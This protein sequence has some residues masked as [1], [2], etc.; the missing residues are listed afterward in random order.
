MSAGVD[1]AANGGSEPAAAPPACV[2]SPAFAIPSASLPAPLKGVLGE[3]RWQLV[4]GAG[5]D[6]SAGLS[7]VLRWAGGPAPAGTDDLSV[8][9]EFSLAVRCHRRPAADGSD[10]GAGGEGGRETMSNGC[11][12]LAHAFNADSPEAGERR[13]ACSRA[14]LLPGPACP[15]AHHRAP[16][17]ATPPS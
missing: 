2:A 15:A 10:G 16:L 14:L 13:Q 9:C 5:D 1:S 12:W 17:H 3:Q 8:C 11:S 4:C 6:R 7:A